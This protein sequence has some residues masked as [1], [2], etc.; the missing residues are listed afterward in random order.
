M[1][2]VIGQRSLELEIKELL[3][4]KEKCSDLRRKS[5]IVKE[6]GIKK[7]RLSE[8]RSTYVVEKGD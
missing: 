5:E 1:F 3:E 7:T 8:Y 6:I 4:E 2:D